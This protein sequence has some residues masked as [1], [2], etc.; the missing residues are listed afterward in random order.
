LFKNKYL[1][2]RLKA[3][4]EVREAKEREI[5]EEEARKKRKKE[6]LCYFISYY[7][8]ILNKLLIKF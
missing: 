2:A 4:Q 1:E 3:E 6:V 8:K 7:K 5:I